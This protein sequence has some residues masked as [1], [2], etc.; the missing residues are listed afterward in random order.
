M[1]AVPVRRRDDDPERE[2]RELAQVEQRVCRDFPELGVEDVH[3]RV[4]QQ[5]TRF[6]DST[7]RIF[8]P[9]LV[10]RGVRTAIRGTQAAKLSATSPSALSRPSRA[11]L[12]YA[13]TA[14]EPRV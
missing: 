5:I 11:E 12:P 3:E 6:A 2:S 1:P 10:E 9:L 7:V 14:P 4:G 8:V 13:A